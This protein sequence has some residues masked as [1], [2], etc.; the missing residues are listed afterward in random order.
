MQTNLIQAEN[1]KPIVAHKVTDTEV[2]IV[3]SV[4]RQGVGDRHPFR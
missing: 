1:G 2:R 4:L 3:L